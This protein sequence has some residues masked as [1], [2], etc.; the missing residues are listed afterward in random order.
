MAENVIL[1][2]KN[3]NSNQNEVNM[4]EVV[5]YLNSELPVT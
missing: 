2:C 3:I 1:C 5:K 4:N